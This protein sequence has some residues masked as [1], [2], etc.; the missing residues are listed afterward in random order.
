MK[1]YLI[2][3]DIDKIKHFDQIGI[4]RIFIDLEKLGKDDRQKN[5]DTV[6]SNHTIQDIYNVKP[7][8]KRAELLVRVDP[9]NSNSKNQINDVIDAGAD[10]VMLPFFKTAEEVQKFIDFVNGRAKT[11]IL[12]ETA[13]AF[14]R[15]KDIL[16]IDGI[17]E[18]HVGLNDLSIDLDLKFMFEIIAHRFLVPLT[19]Y[20]KEKGIFFGIGG[21]AALDDGK[22]RGRSILAEYYNLGA[23]A[24]I[25]S[26]TF[27][28][29]Y[30]KDADRFE[31][32]YAK[33]AIEWSGLVNRE[34]S[35]FEDNIKEINKIVNS[36]I[37]S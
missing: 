37:K 4:D 21:V 16:A 36:I 15:F 32:E 6:K 18:V 34:E 35:F 24:T 20:L 7:I 17:D 1:Y 11:N 22:L 10:V 8:L 14:V 5:L 9:I 27:T 28:K 26:R 13:A 29:I 19:Q 30:N 25:L 12:I 2:E 3:N 33:L 31:E 23:S